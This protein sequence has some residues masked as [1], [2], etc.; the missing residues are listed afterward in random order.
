MFLISL[1]M[2]YALIGIA[3]WAMF[4]LF[5]DGNFET[6]SKEDRISFGYWDQMPNALI[7][8]RLIV[9]W[10]QLLMRLDSAKN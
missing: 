10:I 4:S 7:W 8:P 2:M 6:L 1:L 9:V 5:L 3:V